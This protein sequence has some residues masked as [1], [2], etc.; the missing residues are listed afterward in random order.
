[1]RGWIGEAAARH[2]VFAGRGFRCPASSI[3]SLLFEDCAFESGSGLELF[4]K[5]SRFVKPG[6][7][8]VLWGR[9]GSLVFRRTSVT[10]ARL[11]HLQ[12]GVLIVAES[13]L[14][15]ADLSWSR[16][17]TVRLQDA[18]FYGLLDL[19]ETTICRLEK[20]GVSNSA[21]M[22]GRLIAS[23]DAPEP[24]VDVFPNFV[25]SMPLTDVSKRVSKTKSRYRDR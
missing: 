6:D 13:S 16:I 1:M 20:R 3:D 5:A 7:Q 17:G 15:D 9:G 10:K 19:T 2:T 14:N 18:A 12:I 22:V 23:V 24:N 25:R 11:T 8:L 21:Q 4:G